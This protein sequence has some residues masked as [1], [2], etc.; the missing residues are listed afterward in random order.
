MVL[1][2][3]SQKSALVYRYYSDADHCKR[4]VAYNGK[5]HSVCN[6]IQWGGNLPKLPLNMGDPDPQLTLDDPQLIFTLLED[7]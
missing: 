7:L 5:L 3:S 1:V 4:H 2:Q 6:A